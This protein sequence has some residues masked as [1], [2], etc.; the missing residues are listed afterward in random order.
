VVL[1][2]NKLQRLHPVSHPTIMVGCY[3]FILIL[4]TALQVTVFF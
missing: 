1:K 4:P 2:I 3:F